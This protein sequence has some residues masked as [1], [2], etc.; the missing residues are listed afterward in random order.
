MWYQ[1][2][3]IETVFLIKF[4]I[5]NECLRQKFKYRKYENHCAEYELKIKFYKEKVIYYEKSG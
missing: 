2:T 1:P 3:K 4:L 5:I